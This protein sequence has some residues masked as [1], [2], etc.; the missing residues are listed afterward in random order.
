MILEEQL[1]T[2][3]VTFVVWL[4]TITL[5]SQGSNLRRLGRCFICWGEG[6]SGALEFPNGKQRQ[7]G[8][9]SISILKSSTI[10]HSQ[11]DSHIDRFAL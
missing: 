10:L 3:I 8:L 11:D 4:H 5:P 9:C 6:N 2:F 7:T 1:G